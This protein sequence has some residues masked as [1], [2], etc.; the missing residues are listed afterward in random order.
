MVSIAGVLIEFCD[1]FSKNYDI[2]RTGRAAA[3]C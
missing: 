1:I 3:I 2:E